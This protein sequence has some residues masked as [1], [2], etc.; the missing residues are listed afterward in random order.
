MRQCLRMR[1]YRPIIQTEIC[2]RMKSISVQELRQ[3]REAGKPFLLVDVREEHERMAY[4]IG[5][6]HLPMSEVGDTWK[7]L[8]QELPVVVYCAKG[9]RSAIFI[10]RLE[11]AQG[12]PPM[13][14]LE[15]GLKNWNANSGS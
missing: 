7:V 1:G 6:L 5:G 10:Q 11:R 8:Q 9:I 14:N 13:Y 12:M 2:L 4:H 3:W 15:G